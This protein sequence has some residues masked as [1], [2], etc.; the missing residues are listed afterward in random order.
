MLRI[1]QVESDQDRAHV[2]ELF[3]EY[4]LQAN[5]GLNAEFGINFPIKQILEE[6]MLTLNKF[7]PPQGR[8]L[9]AGVGDHIV[10]LACMKQ[11]REGMGEVKRM[12]VRDEF[13]GQGIGRALLEDLIAAAR[14]IGYT[15]L[16]LDSA[17][18]MS[19]AHNLYRSAG[20]EEIDP[21]PESEIPEEFQANWIF[22]EREL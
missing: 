16:R 10:G 7:S 14:E 6:D 9:L 13:R 1:Y 12:Y 11:I 3:G 15:Y 21:Y 5:A 17:R 8:L 2:R 19:A 20:F 18:F 4:L 22:M